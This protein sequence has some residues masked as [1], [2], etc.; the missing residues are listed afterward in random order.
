M[1]VQLPSEGKQRSLGQTAPFDN[2]EWKNNY[3]LLNLQK[4]IRWCGWLR[5]K[6]LYTKYNLDWL[7]IKHALIL[8]IELLFL[9]YI[10]LLKLI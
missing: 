7:L 9:L 2:W 6:T 4:L 3:Q 10:Y 5:L 8:N 1:W